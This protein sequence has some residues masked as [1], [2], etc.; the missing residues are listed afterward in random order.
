MGVEQKPFNQ[1][2]VA[3]SLERFDL[4]VDLAAFYE[5]HEGVGLESTPERLLRLCQLDEITHVGWRDL[6]VLGEEDVPGWE[7]FAAIR[8]GMSAFFD[9]VLYVT[10]CPCCESGAILCIGIDVSGPGGVGDARFE[11]SL[12]LATSLS[13]WLERLERFNWV[14]YGLMPGQLADLSQDDEWELRSHFLRLN[15]AISW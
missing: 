2:P 6:H 13:D 5:R 9:E 3:R 7:E 8:I 14:E 4:P 12:V 11:C 10:D 1:L 15:P